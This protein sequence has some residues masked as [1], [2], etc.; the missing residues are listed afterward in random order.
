MT[1]EQLQQLRKA[2]FLDITEAAEFIGGVSPRTWQRWEKG[3]VNV[4]LDVERKIK[5]LNEMQNQALDSVLCESIEYSYKYY[6][7]DEFNARFGSDKLRWRLYQ[8][9][10]A[11]VY[12]ILGDP[13][14]LEE[15]PENC[16]LYQFFD[17]KEEL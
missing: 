15:A 8:S 9:V 11:R 16:A 3:D 12:Q 10:L 4:P 7:Y 14:S 2:L 6:N 5:K 1:K 13:C 17:K